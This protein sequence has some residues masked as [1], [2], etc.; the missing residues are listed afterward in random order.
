M[1]NS[2]F[3]KLYNLIMQDR[4]E[5]FLPRLKKYKVKY[6]KF[7]VEKTLQDLLALPSKESKL[8]C[9]LIVHDLIK[10]VNDKAF[11]LYKDML[12]S[13]PNVDINNFSQIKKLLDK[14]S[15]K[16]K[17]NQIQSIYKELDAR[18]DCFTKKQEYDNDVIIYTLNDD[19]NAM[20]QV[21]QIV[22]AFK[23]KDTV[24]WCLVKRD[25]KGD[26][27]QGWSNWIKYNAY[28]KQIAFQKGKLIGFNA[29]ESGQNLW[30]NTNDMQLKDGLVDL[31]GLPV[32]AKESKPYSE[33][34][35]TNLTIKQLQELEK[36]KNGLYYT[37]GDLRITNDLIKDG[38]LPIKLI[39]VGGN[40]N[41]NGC[42]ALKS[43][44]GFPKK[45]KG[46]VGFK[47]C[48]ALPPKELKEWL[49]NCK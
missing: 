26:M 14:Q 2:K 16:N 1:I 49:N 8:A 9:T 11:N 5:Q 19:R 46:K 38:K 48:Y 4:T 37:N 10:G 44:E 3:N 28:P 20:R 12:K 43:L 45:V 42:I 18:Y 13:Y 22:D 36:D 31:N 24:I 7:N 27:D 39:Y 29:N 30:W 34:R 47:D 32:K 17:N 25:Q 15:T 6:P 23:S 33:S 35:R 21:R 41:I 40:F